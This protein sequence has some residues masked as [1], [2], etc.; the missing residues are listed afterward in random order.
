MLSLPTTKSWTLDARIQ[1]LLLIEI[2]ASSQF[3]GHQ[4]VDSKGAGSNA[5]PTYNEIMD[6]GCTYSTP[7]LD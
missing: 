1:H 7:S 3:R 2:I 4:E 6:A 5:I